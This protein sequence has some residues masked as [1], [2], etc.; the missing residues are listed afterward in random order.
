MNYSVVYLPLKATLFEG[1]CKLSEIR[2]FKLVFL[3]EGSY[4]GA[5]EVL[6]RSLDSAITE[7]L[8]DFLDS[9]PTIRIV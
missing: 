9:P 1:L 8:L 5:G 7:G 3:L 2:P 6:A 4:H